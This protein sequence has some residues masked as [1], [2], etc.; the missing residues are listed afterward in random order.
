MDS[1]FAPVRPTQPS[2][3]NRLARQPRS[4]LL[5]AQIARALGD[6][7]RLP[8]DRDFDRFLP[9][10][11]RRAS[12]RHWTPLVV[13]ARA[14]AWLEEL[15]VHTV[16]DIGSGAGKFCVA[17]ALL[18]SCHFIG[19]EQR[20]RL[21][22]TAEV[23]ARLYGIERRA[24][25]IHETFGHVSPPIADAYYLF[26]PFEENLCDWRSWLDG[27]VELSQGRFS[28]DL[29]AARRWLAW[30]A[31]GTYVLT[32]NGMGGSLPK[33]YREVRVDRELPCVLK[34]WRQE[35]AD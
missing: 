13:V 29:S 20:E 8:D 26:N 23:L 25:F 21:V 30:T 27:G 3:L 12:P 10:E 7:K 17:G 4:P 33:S 16:V 31:P 15:G 24:S 14:A 28:R 1:P 19:I 11:L 35:R 5:P 32:Y 18:S 6:G 2:E 22:A 9:R 34:L